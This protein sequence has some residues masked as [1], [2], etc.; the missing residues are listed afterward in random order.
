MCVDPGSSPQG[1][2]PRIEDEIA[3]SR[4]HVIGLGRSESL[5]DPNFSVFKA[6]NS[7]QAWAR[8]RPG[9]ARFCSPGIVNG[10]SGIA[11]ALPHSR[12]SFSAL[13]PRRLA[14]RHAVEVRSS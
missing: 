2:V 4:P 7:S 14:G 6:R 9:F 5:I 12:F 10:E 3:P 13:S 11:D 8:K 1:A